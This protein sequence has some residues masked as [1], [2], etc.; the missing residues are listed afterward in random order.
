M[1]KFKQREEQ[2]NNEINALIKEKNRLKGELDQIQNDKIH[3]KQKADLLSFNRAVNKEKKINRDLNLVISD[4]ATLEAKLKKL[5]REEKQE[6]DRL[7]RKRKHEE[8]QRKTRRLMDDV[9]RY[10]KQ[11]KPPRLMRPVST[12]PAGMIASTPAQR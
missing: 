1:S 9:L 3:Y 4:L 7:E 11:G 12:I 8:K 10:M 2:Y 6:K 5:K